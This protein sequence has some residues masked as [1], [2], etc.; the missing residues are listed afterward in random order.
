[1]TNSGKQLLMA[2]AMSSFF[3]DPWA[4][5]RQTAFC[6]SLS[7][8]LCNIIHPCASSGKLIDVLRRHL[9]NN[10]PALDIHVF[11]VSPSNDFRAKMEVSI[12]PISSAS[13][14]CGK[15]LPNKAK[16]YVFAILF[17]IQGRVAMFNAFKRFPRQQSVHIGSPSLRRTL[18][19]QRQ[20]FV[21]DPN[22]PTFVFAAVFIIS[23]K[24]AQP[25]MLLARGHGRHGTTDG[26]P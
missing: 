11:S 9:S 25:T 23:A 14:F 2:F 7:P 4:R 12:S 17:A 18:V 26:T 1:M 5:A 21:C 3:K 22:F 15:R 19:T 10:S 13:S 24:L 8:D 16:K 6:S 20:K